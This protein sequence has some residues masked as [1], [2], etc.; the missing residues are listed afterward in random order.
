MT[1]NIMTEQLYN[2]LLKSYTKG[3]FGK[4]NK[5]RYTQ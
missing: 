4:Y 3:G 2:E 5:G 1:E